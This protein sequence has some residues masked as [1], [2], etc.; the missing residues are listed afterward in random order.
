L[1]FNELQRQVLKS[2]VYGRF[3]YITLILMLIVPIV[4]HGQKEY[5]E[6]IGLQKHYGFAFAHKDEVK[7]ISGARP[8]GMALE[9]TRLKFDSASYNLANCYPKTGI[10]LMY[11]NYN[12][13]IVGHS[14]SA[15]YFIEPSLAISDRW[16]V[17]VR[18]GLGLSYLTN[19]YDPVKNPE[20]NSYSLPVSMFFQFGL[21]SHFRTTRQLGFNLSA[22]FLHVSNGG[23][24]YPNAGLNWPTFNA[25]LNYQLNDIEFRKKNYQKIKI[26]K[27]SN[28]FEVGV[29]SSLKIPEKEDKRHFFVPGIFA[30]YN[31]QFRQL[32]TLGLTFDWHADFALSTLQSKLNEQKNYYFVSLALDHGFLMGKFTFWQQVGYYLVPP[33]SRFQHWYHRWGLHYDLSKNLAVGGSVKV[34]IFTAHIADLRVVY[35]FNL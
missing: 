14:V 6:H 2:G 20:N 32:H 33:D 9:Y 24:Y 4:L 22:N 12:N 28:R 17:A 23:I 27:T 25:G 18:G 31:R 29:Y 26:R 10:S 3:A 1:T 7:F 21:T 15:V 13:S 8:F 30:A 35:R 11:F 19:P 34:H 16:L 5:I